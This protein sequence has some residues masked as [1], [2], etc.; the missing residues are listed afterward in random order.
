MNNSVCEYVKPNCELISPTP[1]PTATP[2]H[3]PTPSPSP[4]PTPT[5]SDPCRLETTKKRCK[6]VK[7]SNKNPLCEWS[8]TGCNSICRS[9]KLQKSKRK[10]EQTS[11]CHWAHDLC[12]A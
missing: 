2:S 8:K 3:H 1:S 9:S 12:H 6:K 4:S 5:W 10:C 7:D 11:S